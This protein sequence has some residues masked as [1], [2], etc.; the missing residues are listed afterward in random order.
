MYGLEEFSE[1]IQKSL[2]EHCE[3]AH[4]LFLDRVTSVCFSLSLF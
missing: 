1:E 3:A 2:Q 4:E